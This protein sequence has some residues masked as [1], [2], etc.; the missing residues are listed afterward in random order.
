MN[1]SHPLVVSA[2]LLNLLLQTLGG[3]ERRCEEAL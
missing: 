3:I 1:V 2:L